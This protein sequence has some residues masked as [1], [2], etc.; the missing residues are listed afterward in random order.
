MFGGRV[1]LLLALLFIAGVAWCVVIL[2]RLPADLAELSR[3]FKLYR[4]SRDPHVLGSIKDT[5]GRRERFRRDAAR[6]FWMTLAVQVLF[7]WP[8][9]AVVLVVLVWLGCAIVS[10]IARAL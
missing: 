5:H 8:I 6:D 4:S 1:G 2:R 9:T 3:T 10:R 7:F